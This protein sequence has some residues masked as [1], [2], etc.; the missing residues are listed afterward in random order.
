[1]AIE[2]GVR[3]VNGGP[4]TS[5]NVLLSELQAS[6]A[7]SKPTMNSGEIRHYCTLEIDLPWFIR[8]RLAILF[9]IAVSGMFHNILKKK[10]TAYH[11][12]ITLCW[13]WRTSFV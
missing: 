7:N 2:V 9:Y 4:T 5:V 10:H 8:Y 11:F 13:S 3:D 12:A 1:M 6:S